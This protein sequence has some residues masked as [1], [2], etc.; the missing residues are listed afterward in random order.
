L[1]GRLRTVHA[2]LFLRDVWKFIAGFHSV[3]KVPSN[4][5]ANLPISTGTTKP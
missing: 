4:L 3:S 5:S 2:K 1:C